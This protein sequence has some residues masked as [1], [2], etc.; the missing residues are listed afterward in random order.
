MTDQSP[1]AALGGPPRVDGKFLAVNDRRFL[2]KGVAYGTFAPASDGA[3]FPHAARIAEDFGLMAAA[4]INTLRTYTVPP[5]GLLDEAARRG[6]HVMV[7]IP[8]T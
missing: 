4:G 8:W 2:V 6:L 5:E 7:G 1:R 3:Q